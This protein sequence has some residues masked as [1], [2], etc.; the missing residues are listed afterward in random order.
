M[1]TITNHK[2]IEINN[3]KIHYFVSGNEDGDAILFLHPAFG[4]HTCF[5]KQVDYFSDKYKI[6]TLD[7]LGHGLTSMEKTKDKLDSTATHII[8]ILKKEN[9]DKCHIV[10]VS[11]GSLLAQDFA[12]N[13]PNKVVSLTALGGYS[14][15]KEQKEINKA[16]GRELFKWLFKMIFSMESFRRYIASVA[17]INKEEQDRFFNSSK[18]F[19]R[20]SFFVMSGL[21]KIIANRTVKWTF[22]LLILVGEK[23]NPL[24]IRAAKNWYKD[25]LSPSEFHIIENAG[26]CA[27][28]DNS[29]C[30]NR[31]LMNFITSGK[32]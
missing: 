13:H 1:N 8:G 28:M 9:I 23:D 14:I 18:H 32:K 27:N 25:S 4:D 26:H 21:N 31:I 19:T 2:T 11:M 29:E 3:N 17:A 10:G 30:F 6:I 15:N 20:T 22:P 24:A 12:N 5:D 16:Q 7:I